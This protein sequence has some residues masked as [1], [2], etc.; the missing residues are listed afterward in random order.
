MY[1]T[2]QNIKYCFYGVILIDYSTNMPTFGFLCVFLLLFLLVIIIVLLPSSTATYGRIP[3]LFHLIFNIMVD[4]FV[5]GNSKCEPLPGVF[6]SFFTGGGVGTTAPVW[7]TLSYA[8]LRSHSPVL[9]RDRVSTSTNQAAP[10]CP[11]FWCRN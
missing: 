9:I 5:Q 11:D 7:T 8:G 10:M 3:P 4:K 1:R 2:F 6:F